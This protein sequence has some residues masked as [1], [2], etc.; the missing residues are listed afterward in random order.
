METRS[1]VTGIPLQL[2][3]ISNVTTEDRK[4]FYETLLNDFLKEAWMHTEIPEELKKVYGPDFGDMFG[5]IDMWMDAG[6]GPPSESWD[7]YRSEMITESHLKMATEYRICHD[8]IYQKYDA[9]PGGMCGE[10]SR[11]IEDAKKTLPHKF[12]VAVKDFF[13]HYYEASG[14][15]TVSVNVIFIDEELLKDK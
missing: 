11:L 4:E 14:S 2:T 5:D 15:E 8:T 10:L 7:Q 9:T 6:E 3:R 12:K 13:Y 1:P